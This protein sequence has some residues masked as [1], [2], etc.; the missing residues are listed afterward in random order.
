MT[1]R[2][3]GENLINNKKWWKELK[4]FIYIVPAFFLGGII[5]TVGGAL[6]E[7]QDAH[8]TYL[9]RIILFTL[10]GGSAWYVWNL[11]TEPKNH[12]KS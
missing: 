12:G 11:F 8:N 9:G 2:T 6:A 7:I 3:A 1:K 5:V 4:R 10:V